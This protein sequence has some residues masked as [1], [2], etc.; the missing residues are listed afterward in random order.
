M[1][2]HALPSDLARR[3][4]IRALSDRAFR[5]HAALLGLCAEL[6]SPVVRIPDD[7]PPGTASLADLAGVDNHVDNSVLVDELGRTVT[8]SVTGPTVT[9]TVTLCVTFST[10]IKNPKGAARA[11][12]YRTRRRDSAS[13]SP[14]RSAS[15]VTPS[16]TPRSNERS[17]G[18]RYIS[19]AR[20]RL[21]GPSDS[22]GQLAL[23]FPRPLA[24]FVDLV[25][26]EEARR[27]L[28]PAPIGAFVLD[29]LAD[30]IARDGEDLGARASN[31]VEDR[32]RTGAPSCDRMLLGNLE[33]ASCRW[34]AL[35]WGPIWKAHEAAR[36]LSDD[37]P[38]S[39]RGGPPQD[40]RSVL[41]ALPSNDRSERRG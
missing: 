23:T 13:R 25:A 6:G 2:T 33:Q 11:R 9:L 37:E 15:R 34:S 29:R 7:L 21:E 31:L 1:R 27:G 14:S 19:P 35:R 22:G 26:R 28:P 18:E 17:E 16:V 40:I 8:K 41:R 3:P 10:H 39:V 5:L 36:A 4:E 30:W 12:L 20:A 24:E 32:A 38:Q